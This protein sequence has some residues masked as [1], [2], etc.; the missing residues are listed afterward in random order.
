MYSKKGLRLKAY[1]VIH[2][3]YAVSILDLAQ[4]LRISKS[5][6]GRVMLDLFRAKRINVSFRQNR[7]LFF[8]AIREVDLIKPETKAVRRERK[9]P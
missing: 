4:A 9:Q 2:D 7:R 1:R 8:T 5:R 6:A 3:S